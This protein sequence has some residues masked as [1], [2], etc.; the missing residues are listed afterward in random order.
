[1]KLGCDKGRGR[2]GEMGCSWADGPEAR[3]G[4]KNVFF[5]FSKFS[6]KFLNEF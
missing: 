2:R 1:V 6:K 3:E 5:F 4:R